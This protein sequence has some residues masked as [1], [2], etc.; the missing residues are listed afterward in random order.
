MASVRDMRVLKC[1]RQ[2]PKGQRISDMSLI[3]RFKK[4]AFYASLYCL[5]LANVV[6]SRTIFQAIAAGKCTDR[7]QHCAVIGI[8][9]NNQDIER[10][11]Y[12]T[13]ISAK[14]Y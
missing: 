8:L 10:Y 5:N 4:I 6:A 3:E 12:V 7:L 14:G 2:S 13:D 9:Q 1:H 11:Q